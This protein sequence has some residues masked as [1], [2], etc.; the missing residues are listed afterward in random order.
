MTHE[1][2]GK[3]NNT[4]A[5]FLQLP[6]YFCL[7]YRL[8]EC[9]LRL[10]KMKCHLH[11]LFYF[12]PRFIDLLVLCLCLSVLLFLIFGYSWFKSILRIILSNYRKNKTHKES[13]KTT[14][15]AKCCRLGLNEPVKAIICTNIFKLTNLLFYL[16]TRKHG[17]IFVM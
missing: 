11:F 3:Y 13:S 17:T 8:T 6:Q 16:I 10:C 12:G 14:K 5:N 15:N 2:L 7:S 1:R 9:Y 4:E